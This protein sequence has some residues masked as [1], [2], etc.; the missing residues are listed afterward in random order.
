MAL[1][2]ARC[3]D[4]ENLRQ[5]QYADETNECTEMFNSI[6]HYLILYKQYACYSQAAAMH[7]A[8]P[9]QPIFMCISWGCGQPGFVS[10]Q[11]Q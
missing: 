8:N 10:R 6:E 7:M 5:F 1:Q 11:E 3:N 4:E 2:N 9:L